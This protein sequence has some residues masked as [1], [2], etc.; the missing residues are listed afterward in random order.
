[1][2]KDGGKENLIQERNGKNNLQ[3]LGH[4]KRMTDFQELW[5]QLFGLYQIRGSEGHYFKKSEID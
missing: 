2:M 5:E 4:R 3:I 1:M